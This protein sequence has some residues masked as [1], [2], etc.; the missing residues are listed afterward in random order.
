MTT[1][2][3]A[4]SPWAPPDN[5]PERTRAEANSSE[6]SVDPRSNPVEHQQ[7]P[8]T[9][10]AGGPPPGPG[11]SRPDQTGGFPAGPPPAPHPAGP[12]PGTGAPGGPYEPGPQQGPRP[13]APYAQTS[14]WADPRS[15]AGAGDST[16]RVDQGGPATGQGQQ[17][18]GAW[19]NPGHPGWGAPVPPGAAPGGQAPG[20]QAPGS[21][22]GSDPYGRFTPAK[23]NPAPM[24]RRRMI[25][26]ALAI[27]LVSGGI[28]GGVGAL[29]AS[30]DSPAVVTSSAGL[31]QSTGTAGVSPA[32]DN[33]V[34]AAAQAILPSVVT[35]AEQSSQES[36][37]GSGTIIR[38]DGY[39]LTNNHVVS[40]ASQGGTLTVT[41]QDGRTFD[42]QVKATDPSS[43]LAVVKIDATGLP[44]ATFGDSDALQVG[45]LVVAVGSPLGLNGTVTSGIVSSL[46]RPVRTGDATVRDQQNTVL[47]AIQTDAP[48]NPGNS[49]GPLVNSKG[50]II[51]VNT[52]IATVGGSSPFGGSQQSGNI[53]VGFAIPGNYAEKVAGQLVDNGAAQHPYLGVSASTADEN[54][55][56]TAASGT[57]AQIRS[58]VSGGPADKAGLHVGDVITKVGDR[59][60]TDVDSLIAAVRSYEIGNQV[61]VTYQR[62]GSSQ[63][64]T[65][66]LLE[67]PPNS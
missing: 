64:A 17:Q 55:R 45:E 59:A 21:P 12:A 9:P 52:A 50:E 42:A 1:T 62:D 53:G 65:V 30:D 49:G 40:G 67:Q 8:G 58:L 57:G 16:Q 35:I 13:T 38:A 51:G 32:A 18:S 5:A 11:P 39:I 23:P 7:Y 27:A 61:Q 6:G 31:R 33:T 4:R 47:D 25:A 44:A 34:A 56:S 60:V 2:H 19:W 43:D 24:R 29:V 48:I 10:P 3:D 66:T 41:M 36:G 63:T 37:T 28:G 26:A 15:T 22:G 46:H 14:G 54:T 20:G